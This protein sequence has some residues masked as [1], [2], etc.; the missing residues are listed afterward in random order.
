LPFHIKGTEI[1]LIRAASGWCNE[2]Y[3]DPQV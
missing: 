2:K 3:H 1:D